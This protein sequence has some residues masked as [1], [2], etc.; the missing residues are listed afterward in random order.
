M[1]AD[2]L[3]KKNAGAEQLLEV[4]ETGQLPAGVTEKRIDKVIRK[5]KVNKA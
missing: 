5:E 1:L 2:P 4:L 3:T